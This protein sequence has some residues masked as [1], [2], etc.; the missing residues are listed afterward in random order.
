MR[1][2]SSRASAA[3]Q[4]V[5]P[6]RQAAPNGSSPASARPEMLVPALLLAI[7]DQQ[8]DAGLDPRRLRAGARA[9]AQGL[10]AVPPQPP[11][12]RST[13]SSTSPRL[14]KFTVSAA[15]GRPRA[16]SSRWPRNTRTSAWR[17]R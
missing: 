16:A 17:K 5:S 14:R 1:R 4:R 7:G 8:L 9:L 15:P 12:A 6:W 13:A 10:E 2:A 11:N 3:R